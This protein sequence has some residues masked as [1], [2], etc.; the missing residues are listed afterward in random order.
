MKRN[1]V[2]SM[3]I[4]PGFFSTKAVA[5][6]A[7]LIERYG[8]EAA[9][10]GEKGYHSEDVLEAMAFLQKITNALARLDRR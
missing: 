6:L 1:K 5:D 9:R 8:V 7:Y 10:V 2:E 3:F 4:I